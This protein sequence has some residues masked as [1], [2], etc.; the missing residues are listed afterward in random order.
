MKKVF[1]LTIAVIALLS[2]LT[3]NAGAVCTD[4]AAEADIGTPIVALHMDYLD[5]LAKAAGYEKTTLSENPHAY[6]RYDGCV[7]ETIWI[8]SLG[9]YRSFIDLST[10]FPGAISVIPVYF[11][12]EF[13]YTSY[14]PFLEGYFHTVSLVTEDA[15]MEG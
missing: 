6:R 9:T 3:V 7:M 8:D 11:E 5:E 2:A 4:C 12:D 13:I 10:G 15:A 1:V 14:L